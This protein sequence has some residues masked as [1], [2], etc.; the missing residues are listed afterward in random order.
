MVTLS[1]F[2]A[3]TGWTKDYDERLEV[4]VH[5]PYEEDNCRKIKMN[6]QNLAKYANSEV[7]YIDS[8]MLNKKCWITIG[9]KCA[10][11]DIVDNCDLYQYYF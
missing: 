7:I 5:Y 8:D 6:I 10:E 3:A 2:I 1:D 11:G 9:I 4:W